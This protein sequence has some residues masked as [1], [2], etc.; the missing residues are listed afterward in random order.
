MA[1][2]AGIH[3]SPKLRIHQQ[4]AQKLAL[5]ILSGELPQGSVLPG[6]IEQ[7]A[8]MDVSRTPYREAIRILAA[9]G[10]LE[11]RPKTGTR[12]TSRDRW[13]VL[14]P[15]VLAWMFMGEPNERFI[16]DLFELRRLIEPAAARLAA[17]RQT[18]EHITKM[19]EALK[20]MQ[21]HGLASKGGQEADQSFHRALLEAAGNEALGSLAST[22]GAAVQWTTH[23]KQ[24]RS[25]NPRDPFPEHEAVFQA[26]ERGDPVASYAAMEELVRLAEE[27]MWV[28]DDSNP[29]RV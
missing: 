2:G 18:A 19:R 1:G 21:T 24:R 17:L 7:A 12:V 4:V 14:D 15:E 3:R 8:A 5:A 29:K 9:K 28:H 22:V 20:E 16:R 6:E 23:Y 25:Q 13:N 10:F 26:I 11:S 27:D